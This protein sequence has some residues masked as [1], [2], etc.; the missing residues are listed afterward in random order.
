[1]TASVARPRALWP[2]AT[3]VRSGRP[4]ACKRGCSPTGRRTTS[5]RPPMSR[6]S[7]SRPW[8]TG[9]PGLGARARAGPDPCGALATGGEAAPLSTRARPGMPRVFERCQ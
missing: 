8:R 2:L 6:H 1:M 5:G 7:W 3:A 9:L 4:E